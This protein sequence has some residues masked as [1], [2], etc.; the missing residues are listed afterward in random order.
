[1]RLSRFSVFKLINLLVAVKYIKINTS[2]IFSL[3][4]KTHQ[5]TNKKSLD[6]IYLFLP[7]LSGENE[8]DP[9]GFKQVN[10]LG[11]LKLTGPENL[12]DLT[13]FLEVLFLLLILFNFLLEDLTY[14]FSSLKGEKDLIIKL[15]NY[16]TSDLL[17]AFLFFLPLL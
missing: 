6:W 12:E 7:K 11:K 1:M 17:A 10:T 13:F 2:R 9:G 8:C 5:E 4:A 15:N 3:K 16:K 14:I